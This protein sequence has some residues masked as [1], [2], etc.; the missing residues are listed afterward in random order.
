MDGDRFFGINFLL[1]PSLPNDP[2]VAET[3]LNLLLPLLAPD[4]LRLDARLLRYGPEQSQQHWQSHE[5]M[6]ES[7]QTNQEEDLE[8]REEDVRL[9]GGQQDKCQEG[10]EASVEDSWPYLRHRADNSLVPNKKK[11]KIRMT[12]VTSLCSKRLP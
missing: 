12:F 2:I 11:L 7:K 6:E 10:R 9:G 8:E 1:N 4:L 5:A 3:Q